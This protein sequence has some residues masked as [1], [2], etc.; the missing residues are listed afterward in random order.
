MIPLPVDTSRGGT[1]LLSAQER[2]VLGES[3]A[4]AVRSE[5]E[6]AG[7]R[8]VF[9]TSGASL[10]RVVDGPLQRIEGALGTRMAGRFVGMRAH[11][12][13]DDVVA[14]ARMARDAGAD[15]LVAVG[16][17]SVIDA[18]KAMLM[19]LGTACSMPL[20]S[21]RTSSAAAVRRRRSTTPDRRCE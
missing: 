1:V 17:G 20:R 13:R 2:V 4:Q 3:A 14:A 18:T 15:L 8:R 12:P 10:S 11:S 21:S 9:V 16:G 7:A 19:C 5:A 6:R